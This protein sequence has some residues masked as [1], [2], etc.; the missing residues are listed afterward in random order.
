VPSHLFA[1]ANALPSHVPLH[2]PP[3]LP[4]NLM[5]HAPEQLALQRPLQAAPASTAHEPWVGGGAFAPGPLDTAAWF[6]FFSTDAIIRTKSWLAQNASGL[7]CGFAVL[8]SFRQD[9]M[10]FVTSAVHSGE[11]LLPAFAVRFVTV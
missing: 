2:R 8:A 6:W 3:H 1:P 9:C 11:T 5:S 10:R 4:V 7:A